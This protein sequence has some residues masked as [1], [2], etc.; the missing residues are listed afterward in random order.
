MASTLSNESTSLKGLLETSSGSISILFP[1]VSLLERIIELYESENHPDLVVYCSESR[2]KSTLT[3]PAAGLL[4]NAISTGHVT[5]LAPEVSQ[6]LSNVVL[7]TDAVG[8]VFET[9]EGPVIIGPDTGDAMDEFM[10]IE[11]EMRNQSSSVDLGAPAKSAVDDRLESELSPTASTMFTETL[12]HID[13]ALY[14]RSTQ[15][16]TASLVLCGSVSG[17]TQISISR[18]AEDLGI[19]SR[20]SVSRVTSLLIDEGYLR[21]SSAD[22]D[23]GRPPHILHLTDEV[24]ESPRDFARVIEAV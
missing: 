5:L 16:L 10:E 14:Y 13:G 15:D 12:N 24:E 17:T 9:Q 23:V 19:S 3:Y 7:T 22:T 11:G 4:Q 2:L 8:A 1:S 20:A 21:T 18:I 6:S